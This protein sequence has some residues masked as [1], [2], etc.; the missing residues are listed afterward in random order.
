MTSGFLA[1]GLGSWLSTKTGNDKS[2]TLNLRST[3][4]RNTSS[5]DTGVVNG[6]DEAEDIA[7]D[8]EVATVFISRRVA[9]VVVGMTEVEEVVEITR[10]L[11]VGAT[12]RRI[13]VVVTDAGALIV[14]TTTTRTADVVVVARL[15]RIAVDVVDD[16]CGGTVDVVVVDVVVVDVVVVVVVTGASPPT[17][18]TAGTVTVTDRGESVNTVCAF[19]TESVIENEPAAVSVDTVAPPPATAVDVT[20]T[21]HMADDVCT[22]EPIAE[23]FVKVKSAPAIVDNVE[24]VTSSEP[25]IVKLIV[26]EIAVTDEAARVTVGATASTL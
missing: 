24:H 8:V 9:M 4:A 13:V 12:T 18:A 15:T 6:S 5:C 23:I 17:P 22:I 20:F 3:T 2:C 26:A 11:V 21:V 19:P 1:S 25:E 10:T 7:N 16:T 14:V